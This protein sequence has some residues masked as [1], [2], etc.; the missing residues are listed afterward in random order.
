[1]SS[2]A[3]FA[4]LKPDPLLRRVVLC[5]GGSLAACGLIVVAM[6]PWSPA[7]LI[8]VGAAW[9][10]LSGWEL[11]RLRRAWSDSLGLR[12]AADGGAAIL[13]N[14]GCWRPASILNGSV[15][16]RRWCWVRLRAGSGSVFAEPLRG[17]C[18]K[19]RDWRR[20]QVIW[21]HVGAAG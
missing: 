18:R 16:L 12:L 2:I 14:D 7:L 1:M 10:S 4:E 17:S 11:A 5:T 6:L 19:C 20:L 8:A 9:A 13:G 15:L 3:Y 21:R